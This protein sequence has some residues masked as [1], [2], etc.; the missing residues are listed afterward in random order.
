[1][2]PVWFGRDLLRPSRVVPNAA[3]IATFTV[4]QI[5]CQP[6]QS[7]ELTFG[8]GNSKQVVRSLQST[9]LPSLP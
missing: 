5:G 4:R 8:P 6:L 1:M 3:M 7:F 2:Q 9:P